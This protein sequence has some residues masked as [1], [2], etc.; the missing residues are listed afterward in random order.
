[1]NIDVESQIN[2]DRV[3]VETCARA[4]CCEN[5]KALQLEF[6]NWTLD[7]LVQP[8]NTWSIATRLI[9]TKHPG[10]CGV[11]IKIFSKAAL[12]AWGYLALRAPT[13]NLASHLECNGVKWTFARHSTVN[14]R[15]S[16]MQLL[17]FE[18]DDR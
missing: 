6:S 1:M 14:E 11:Y 16:L 12:A 17:T 7:G 18:S 15:E 10:S 8:A 2:I 13:E 3:E 9:P 4:G 5:G